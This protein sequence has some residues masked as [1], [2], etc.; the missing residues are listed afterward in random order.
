MMC[1]DN[2]RHLVTMPHIE[3]SIFRWNWAHY[4]DKRN[5]K[6][7]PWILAFKNAKD[8]YGEIPRMWTD[9]SNIVFTS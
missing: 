3:R 8:I 1:S 7:S 9:C 2:G 4:K 5:D 6:V